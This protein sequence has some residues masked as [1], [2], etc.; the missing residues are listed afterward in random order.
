MIDSTAPYLY[1]F[2]ESDITHAQ[3]LTMSLSWPHILAMTLISSA[4][5]MMHQGLAPGASLGF[6]S[7]F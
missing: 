1:L 2:L 3:N 4:R 5:P 6:G 7:Q